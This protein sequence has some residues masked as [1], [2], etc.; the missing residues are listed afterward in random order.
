MKKHDDESKCDI[1]IDDLLKNER[2]KALSSAQHF[3]DYLRASYDRGD[4]LSLE[5]KHTVRNWRAI[6]ADLWDMARNLD[7]VRLPPPSLPH[8]D[9]EAAAMSAIDQL[10]RWVD[11]E[12]PEGKK[13]LAK[14]KQA[15]IKGTVNQRLAEMIQE[16]PSRLSWSAREFAAQLGCSAP[17]V[18]QTET[19]TNTIRRARAMHEAKR[20]DRRR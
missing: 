17:A 19:W 18:I 3:R 6:V 12:Q 13:Q 20:A 11:G 14:P 2:A 10:I 5:R 15:R 7:G 1:S 9:S 8:I 4:I 16:D